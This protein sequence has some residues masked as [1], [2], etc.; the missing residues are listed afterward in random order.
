M[1]LESDISRWTCPNCSAKVVGNA[2]GTN[3]YEGTCPRCR[4]ITYR[5]DKS[6]RHITFEMHAPAGLSFGNTDEKEYDPEWEKD[7]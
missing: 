3:K 2:I 1:N 4:M 6:R 5:I 7:V